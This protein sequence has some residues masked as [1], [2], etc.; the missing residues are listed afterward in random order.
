MADL[1]ITEK[2]NITESSVKLFYG[3]TQNIPDGN[4][5]T[6][7]ATIQGVNNMNFGILIDH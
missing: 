2:Q 4:S 3:R 6:A 5:S 7:D 1:A